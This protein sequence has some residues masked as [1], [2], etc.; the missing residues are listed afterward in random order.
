MKGIIVV[1]LVCAS[2][3]LQAQNKSLATISD[4]NLAS[5]RSAEKVY[6]SIE[7]SAV[8]N[9]E[10]AYKYELNEIRAWRAENT[11]VLF[12]E[13]VEYSKLDEAKQ[14]E[15]KGNV[16]VYRNKIRWTDIEQFIATK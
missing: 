11:K 10:T 2:F 8:T 6:V 12:M 16:I 15:V 3:A 13:A 9:L 14:K 4:P 1:F 7:K 5:K